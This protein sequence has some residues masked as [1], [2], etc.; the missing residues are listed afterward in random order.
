MWWV[1]IFRSPA[2]SLE[3]RVKVFCV[4]CSF[5][6]DDLFF[7]VIITGAIKGTWFFF[8]FAV[9]ITIFA[10]PGCSGGVPTALAVSVIGFAILQLLAFAHKLILLLVSARGTISKPKH[11]CVRELLL[12]GFGIYAFEVVWA[13]YSVVAVLLKDTMAGVDCE[14]LRQPFTAYVV[15][16][17]LNWLELA[18]LALVYFSCLDRC[19]CFCCHAVCVVRCHCCENTT[20]QVA[21]ANE[22][23][24]IVEAK[25]KVIPT[26]HSLSMSH[27][28]G[29][30]REKCC[31]CRRDGLN[32]SKNVALR[33]LT[34]ALAVLYRDIEIHYTALDRLSGWML[35]QKY[36]S[37]LL[38]QGKDSLVTQELLQV[39]T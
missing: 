2:M 12:T 24:S 3:R 25:I 28:C 20:E 23:H 32:N 10:R 15:L 36:H 21:L 31:T 14:G 19:N 30:F 27:L 16:V 11:K 18:L 34:D 17:W 7:P 38:R 35:V 26:S 22:H 5:A 6:P 1:E 13:A 8:A 4:T 37:Q 29:L 39:C 33:D 9:C